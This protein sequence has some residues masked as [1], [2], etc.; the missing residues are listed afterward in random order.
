MAET[1]FA[2]AYTETIEIIN[3]LSQEDYA[4]IPISYIEYL[5][6]NKNA[7]Y[8]FKYDTSKTFNEQN[9]LKETKS[10]LFYLFEKFGAT[11]IQKEKIQNFKNDYYKKIEQEKRLKYNPDDILK[12]NENNQINEIKTE[13]TVVS[14]VPKEKESLLKRILNKIKGIFK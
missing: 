6:K 5:E 9:I 4:K 1:I 13:S 7:N 12:R 10:I 14:L 8:S 2:N 3:Q 11:D